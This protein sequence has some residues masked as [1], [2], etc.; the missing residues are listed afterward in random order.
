MNV[1]IFNVKIGVARDGVAATEWSYQLGRSTNIVDLGCASVNFT[2][3]KKV[4]YRVQTFKFEVGGDDCDE[5]VKLK[6]FDPKTQ[7]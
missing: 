1:N 5:N 7:N 4:W 6:Y 3:N 2:D